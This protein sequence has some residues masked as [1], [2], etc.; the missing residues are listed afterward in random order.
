MRK[1]LARTPRPDPAEVTYTVT[2]QIRTARSMD[3]V[4]SVLG[5]LIT[6]AFDGYIGDPGTYDGMTVVGRSVDL[7]D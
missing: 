6:N 1:I 2:V 5:H 3:D 7:L 4:D